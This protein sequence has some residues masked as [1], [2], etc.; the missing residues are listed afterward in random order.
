M[1]S[2]LV[3]FLYF[4]CG[5]HVPYLRLSLQSLARVRGTYLGGVFIGMDPDDPISSADRAS[6]EKLGLPV[7]FGEWGKVTGYGEV[8][9]LSELAAFRDVAARVAEGDWIAK[10]DSDVLFLSDWIFHHVGQ[11]DRD[12]IGH[13]E[14]AWGTFAY[15]QGGC[16]FLRA[17]FVSKLAAVGR[18]EVHTAADTLLHEFHDVAES[19]GMWKMPQC[20]EDALIHRLVDRHGGRI[21]LVRYYLP[22]WQV[23]RL[24]HNGRRPYLRKPSLVA[25]IA[26]PVI[27]FGIWAHDSMLARDRYSVIH[28]MSCKERM[29]DVFKLLRL[30]GPERLVP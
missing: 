8:T 10:V 2:P 14:Q 19:K 23:D 3:H 28:F 13:K 20:P 12:L 29:S 9:V 22:L 18:D 6:L 24:A 16:Y 11:Q 15:S 17:G 30:Q 25:S 1:I 26:E 7:K 21:K 4:S 27:A 5:A